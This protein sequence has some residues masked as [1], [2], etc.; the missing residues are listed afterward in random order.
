M[1]SQ[2]RKPKAP[3]KGVRRIE[4]RPSLVTEETRKEDPSSP[5]TTADSPQKEPSNGSGI[6]TMEGREYR[7]H[8]QCGGGAGN[9]RRLKPNVKQKE[10]LTN[11]SVRLQEWS[12][13]SYSLA[14]RPKAPD[15][16]VWCR[17]D[18]L[19][20]VL[21]D[22]RGHHNGTRE[23]KCS[24]TNIDQVGS[25]NKGSRM[26]K[27]VVNERQT[28]YGTPSLTKETGYLPVPQ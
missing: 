9:R 25:D 27:E 6:H 11:S 1:Y 15:K 20:I 28:A 21:E 2:A 24:D 23:M 4:D 12:T 16:R 8:I 17:D 3:D 19:P 26:T 13:T 14:R 22:M 5:Q 10:K 7:R 18:K